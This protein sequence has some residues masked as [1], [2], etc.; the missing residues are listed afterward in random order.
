MKKL[1]FL[2]TFFS[3][4]TIP[5]LSQNEKAETGKATYYAKKFHGRKTS[6][7]E[8]LNNDSLTCAH[9]KHPFGTRLKVTNTKNGKSVI[10]R[11]NDRGPF[12]KGM[13]IDLTHAAA[14]AIDMM[15]SGVAKVEIEVVD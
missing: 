3:F 5:A 12:S 1:L 10:V 2:L 15:R 4:L 8:R 14:K 6:S 7:G 9:R 11:V 13:I